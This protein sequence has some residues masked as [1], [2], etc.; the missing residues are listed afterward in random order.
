MKSVDARDSPLSSRSPDTMLHSHEKRITRGQGGHR[1]VHARAIGG[2]PSNN[3]DINQLWRAHCRLRT[4]DIV[5]FERSTKSNGSHA[6]CACGIQSTRLSLV[7]EPSVYNIHAYVYTRALSA[8][9]LLLK[10]R[11]PRGIIHCERGPSR[12]RNVGI[13][14]DHRWL[15]PRKTEEM[16]VINLL[17]LI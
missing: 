2:Y 5:L 4:M 6:R 9:R 12:K 1:D 3:L 11:C 7:P 15:H 16:I 8:V 10:A 17:L 13:T 14:A